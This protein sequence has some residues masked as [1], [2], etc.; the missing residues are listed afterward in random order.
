[1]FMSFLMFQDDMYL[2]KPAVYVVKH[3]ITFCRQNWLMLDCKSILFI[4]IQSVL[5][6]QWECS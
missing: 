2:W 1:M 6:L 5:D 3:T 4:H